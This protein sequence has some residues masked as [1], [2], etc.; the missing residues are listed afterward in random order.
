MAYSL[1]SREEEQQRL[2]WQSRAY[3]DL[4]ALAFKPGETVIEA[5]CGVGANMWIV[6]TFSIGSYIGF[7]I[8]EE[9]IS[10][11]RQVAQDLGIDNAKLF[12][13]D[14]LNE[15]LLDKGIADTLFIRLVLIHLKEPE[16]ALKNLMTF[17]KTGARLIAIEPDSYA[18]TVGPNMPN[19]QRC[20][21]KRCELAYGPQ[22]GTLD[23]AARLDQIFN[24]AGISQ[25]KTRQHLIEV[26]SADE[27][28]LRKFLNSWIV[29]IK[30]VAAQLIEKKLITQAEL[31]A[32]EAE[33]ETPDQ[34]TVLYQ[35]LTICE[36]VVEN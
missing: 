26:T 24:S 18:Y 10:K 31:D 13:G 15:N 5:G 17:C 19:L 16:R 1:G 12:V 2:L 3:G 29:M 11:A 25:V 7:D 23:V 22:Q 4:E 9:Q 28:R 36:G 32:A 27:D 34:N 20:W 6:P 14:I 33:V 35:Y 8:S 30:S 21:Q